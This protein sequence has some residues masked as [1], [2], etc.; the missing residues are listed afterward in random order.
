ME[1]SSPPPEYDTFFAA[2]NASISGPAAVFRIPDE[3]YR[4]SREPVVRSEVYGV[5]PAVGGVDLEEPLLGFCGMSQFRPSGIFPIMEKLPPFIQDYKYILNQGESQLMLVDKDTEN[6]EFH[7]ANISTDLAAYL[8]PVGP[9]TLTV[10]SCDGFDQTTKELQSANIPYPFIQAFNGASVVPT[11]AKVTIPPC[12]CGTTYNA[13]DY[14]FLQLE[15][16]FENNVQSVPFEAVIKTLKMKIR[17]QDV[18]TV[19]DLDATQLYQVTRRNSNFRAN[20]VENYQKYGAV[21][22]SR[23]DLGNFAEWDGSKDDIFQ[24]D[25]EVVEYDV[26]NSGQAANYSVAVTDS[27]NETPLRLVTQFIYRD[28][29]FSGKYNSCKFDFFKK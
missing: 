11:A 10:R 6:N 28:Y 25:F 7:L 29:S 17:F 15:R 27:L 24:V 14:V 3:L 12:A 19:S 26:Y 18:Q 20:A 8:K 2:L 9:Y 16:V 5:A 13:P 23:Y 1:P 21:L 4:R 22:F